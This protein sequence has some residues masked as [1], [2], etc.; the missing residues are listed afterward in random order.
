M[1]GQKITIE[2]DLNDLRVLNAYLPDGS[3]IGV[4]KAAPPWNRTPHT[5]DMRKAVNSL[6][7]RK[8]IHYLT[9]ND[10]IMALMDYY[11][12]TNNK[13]VSPVYLEARRLFSK[14]IEDV[15]DSETIKKSEVTVG[16][17]EKKTKIKPDINFTILQPKTA[18]D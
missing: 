18:K 10:P 9:E 2:I 16:H 1:I 8:R 12:N 4:L 5:Y 13:T 7:H 14:K 15:M 17:I 3:E 11:E 6:V